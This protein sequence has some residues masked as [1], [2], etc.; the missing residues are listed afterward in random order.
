MRKA[1]AQ[2][3]AILVLRR[4]SL[5]VIVQVQVRIVMQQYLNM[6][7]WFYFLLSKDLSLTSTVA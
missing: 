7:T 4:Y 1:Y 3:V 6:I 2:I 5:I